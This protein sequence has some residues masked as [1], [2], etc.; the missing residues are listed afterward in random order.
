M[1]A[2]E[3][4]HPD[5]SRQAILQKFL[6]KTPELLCPSGSLAGEL[7]T[8]PKCKQSL[9]CANLMCPSCGL[10]VYKNCRTIPLE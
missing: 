5:A 4:I 2:N 3:H 9:K 6:K 1:E 10:K 8:N 7:C